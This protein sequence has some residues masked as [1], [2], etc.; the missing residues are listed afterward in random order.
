[1]AVAFGDGIEEDARAFGLFG[2]GRGSVNAATLQF[3]D[4][5][6]RSAKSKEIIRDIPSGTVFNQRAGGGGGYGDPAERPAELVAGEVTDGVISPESAR[7]D[8]KVA[9]DPET[10]EFDP[11]ETERL[12]QT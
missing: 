8:Y 6:E 2:G 7:R 12:R 3:P 5:T 4:G 10:F 1:M 9:V 11:E